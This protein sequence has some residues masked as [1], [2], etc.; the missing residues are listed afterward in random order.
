[1]SDDQ[2]ETSDSRTT[3][4]DGAAVDNTVRVLLT[5]AGLT[6]P[7]KEVARLAQLYPGLRRS[8]DRF[9]DIDTGDEVAAAVFRA[10]GDR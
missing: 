6:V 4:A 2:P 8:A 10:E 1:M 5:E 7:D 3:D 9:Y